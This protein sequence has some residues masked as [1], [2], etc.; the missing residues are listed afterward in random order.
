M[1]TNQLSIETVGQFMRT[2]PVNVEALAGA[3]GLQIKRAIL[4]DNV[5]GKIECEKDGPC[6]ITVN[7]CHPRTRQRFTIAHEIAHFVLHRNQIGDGITDDGRYRSDGL[8][9]SIERQ[10]N[11]YAA[12]ILMPWELVIKKRRDGCVSAEA[13]A[14]EFDV[15][16]AVAEIR[17]R[18]LASLTVRDSTI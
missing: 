17:L 4:P 1:K 5:S 3:L 16:K 18:E 13:L 14:K 9:D 2:A 11:S 10:A 12:D 7:I 8:S 6:I 15:S